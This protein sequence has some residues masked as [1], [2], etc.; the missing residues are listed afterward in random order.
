MTGTITYDAA[1]N[2]ITAVGGTAG[3]PITLR[4]IIDANDAGGWLVCDAFANNQFTFYCYLHI[5]DGTTA[6]YFSENRKFITFGNFMTWGATLIYIK[7]NATFTSGV[8]LNEANKTSANGNHIFVDNLSNQRVWIVCDGSSNTYFY[9]TTFAAATN[10]DFYLAY[11][12]KR[13]WNC[14]LNQAVSRYGSNIDM[15]NVQFYN[16]GNNGCFQNSG[17]GNIYSNLRA[18][19]C[20]SVAKTDGLVTPVFTNLFTRNCT[21]IISWNNNPV[22][23]KAYLVNPD[24]D[25]FYFNFTANYSTVYRQ[26]EFDLKVV[27]ED[28]NYI[29]GAEVNLTKGTTSLDLTTDENGD[30]DTQTLTYGYYDTTNGNNVQ[31]TGDWTITIKKNGYQT[32]SA[33]FSITRKTYLEIALDKAVPVMMTTR[34]KIMTNTEPSNPQ[35]KVLIEL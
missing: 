1:T 6:T 27:D 5:G 32:Y 7:A 20:S 22:G 28:R 10:A 3:T 21:S 14:I 23:M 30:I 19:S 17:A 16:A 9:S 33:P 26:Y 35:S 13:L 8:L 29:E 34:G 12:P 31:D 2:T 11:S 24:V 15:F 18:V 25:N 4:D